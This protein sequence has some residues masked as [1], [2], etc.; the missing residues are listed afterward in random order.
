MIPIVNPTLLEW[1][2]VITDFRQ[3]WDSGQVTTG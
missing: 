1:E 3:A 2:A